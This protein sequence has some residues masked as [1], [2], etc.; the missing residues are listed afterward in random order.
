VSSADARGVSRHRLVSAGALAFAIAAVLAYT[1]RYHEFWRDEVHQEL[2]GA[3]TPLHRF[4]LSLRVNGVPSVLGLFFHFASKVVPPE[5]SL[6]LGGALGY[7]ALLVGTYTCV[8]S[9]CRRPTASLVMTAL[10]AG[11]Y[12]YAYEYGVV[13]RE[14]GFGA[15]LG[16]ATNGYLR[17]AL[18]G[19]SL[20]PVFLATATGALCACTNAH[21]STLSGAAFLAFALVALWHDRG[22]R[23]IWP[24]LGALPFFAFTLYLALPFP[25]R[26]PEGNVNVRQ[27][28]DMFV[29]LARQVVSASFTGRDWWLTTAFGDPNV[30]DVIARLRHWGVLGIALGVAYSTA[31]RL[32]PDWSDYRPVLVYDVLAILLAWLPL[33]E[34]VIHHYWG[35]TR[36]HAFIALPVLV[37][38]AGWGLQRGGGAAPFA[39]AP[40]LA[41]M[42]SWFAFQYTVCVRDLDLDMRLPFSDTKGE[43]ALVPPGAHVVV[44]SLTMQ[45]AFMFWQPTLSVRGG[46]NAG[47]HMRAIAPDPA[48]RMT[49]PVGPLVREECAAAPNA[50]YYS[51][52]QGGAAE[53]APCLTLV[54]AASP[55][56]EQ[57]YTDERFDLWRVDCACAAATR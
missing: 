7:G 24:T 2:Y 32:T 46:D 28:L 35:S 45:E 14:Y 27:P 29:R 41:L 15:G 13:I 11:T 25:G 47:R 51:G 10:F 33:L 3:N 50:T 23:R 17:E 37:V 22:I 42:A 49:V 54:R 31:L 18:R 48:W 44:D 9:I 53:T 56:S 26:T 19:R 52:N 4:V 38:L 43:A 21:S 8:L 5:T 39:G 1:A 30:L 57:P 20:R 55:H 40:A 34:I 12:L 6:L 36:H 16:L